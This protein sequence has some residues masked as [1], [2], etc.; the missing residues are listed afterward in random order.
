MAKQRKPKLDLKTLLADFEH[1]TRLTNSRAT[2]RRYEQALATFFKYFPK[3]KAPEDI[4][5]LD[6]EDY[7]IL[8]IREGRQPNGINLDIST[9]R[10]FYNWLIE[11]RELAVSNPARRPRML[12]TLKR[13]NR[14]ISLADFR[15]LLAVCESNYE[16]ALLLLGASTGMRGGELLALRW[17]EIDRE[18]NVIRLPAHK[19]KSAA[20]RVVPLRKDVLEVLDLLPRTTDRVFGGWTRQKEGLRLKWRALW[21]R[22]GLTPQSLHCLRHTFATWMLRGGSDLRTVQELLGHSSLATTAGYLTA[23]ETDEVRKVVD[24]LPL[25]N[26]A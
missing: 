22:A 6:V 1:Y 4:T 21:A 24:L 14:A 9:V 17:D 12:K 26:R 20:D 2:C 18:A 19:T 7:K 16:R 10:A 8:R 5:R 23:A 11:V 25:E 3:A 13:K 15:A